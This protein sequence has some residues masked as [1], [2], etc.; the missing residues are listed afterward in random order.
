VTVAVVIAVG[1]VAVAL[2]VAEHS[3]A[4]R[5]ETIVGALADK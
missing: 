4:V 5:F 1:F 2:L 3:A